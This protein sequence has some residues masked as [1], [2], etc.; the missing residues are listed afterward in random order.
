MLPSLGYCAPISDPFHHNLIY[1]LEIIQH[2]AACFVLNRPWTRGHHDSI[3]EMLRTLEWTA[4]Q[5]Q[6]SHSRLLLL[7]KILNHHISIPDWYLPVRNLSQITRCNHRVK[8][9]RPYPRNDIYLYSFF[10]QTIQQWNNL[11]ISNL[12]QLNLQKFK[13]FL[14][15]HSL[16]SL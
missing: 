10:P 9:A 16:E 15:N 11:N 14:K 3:T 8:L 2:R 1:Q 5:P 4:L 7:F 6:R 13:N 12:H